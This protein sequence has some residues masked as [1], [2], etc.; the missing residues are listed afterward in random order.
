MT[1]RAVGRRAGA[2]FAVTGVVMSLPGVVASAAADSDGMFFDGGGRG[3][4]PEVAIRGAI[5]DAATSA[6]AYQLYT[7]VPVGEPQV[8]VTDNDPYFGRVFRAQAR[9][10]CTP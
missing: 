1:L 10:F 4:T 3:L 2:M 6:Q 8:F 9:V 7:C 5:G